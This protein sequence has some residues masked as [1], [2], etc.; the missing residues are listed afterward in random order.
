[1]SKTRDTL[2]SKEKIVYETHLHWVLFLEALS[3]ILIGLGVSVIAYEYGGIYQKFVHYCS[4]PFWLY[5]AIKFLME[6][7]Q[8]RSSDFIITNNRV[9]IKVGVINRSSVSMPLSKIESIEIDQTLAG[10][11]FGYGSIHIT[12]TG[13]ATS[14]FNFLANPGKFRQKIQQASNQS[15]QDSNSGSMEIQ[16]AYTTDKTPLIAKRRMRRR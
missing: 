4:L 8:H 7:V 6:W 11:L 5:G 3:Y 13:T 16:N 1:M 12:G 2:S 15:G 9:I 10:Q 14:K